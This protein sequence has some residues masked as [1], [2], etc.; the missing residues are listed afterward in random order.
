MKAARVSE[1]WLGYVKRSGTW[2]ALDKR[3][4]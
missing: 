1:A 3:Q 4:G 2:T